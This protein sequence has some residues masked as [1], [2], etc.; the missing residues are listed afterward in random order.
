ML[1]DDLY[2]TPLRKYFPNAE[3]PLFGKDEEQQKT[4]LLAA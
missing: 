4:Y 3:Y 2:T 1:A